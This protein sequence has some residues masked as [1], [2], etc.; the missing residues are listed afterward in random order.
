LKESEF[1]EYFN[2]RF[3]HVPP[4]RRADAIA[5]L[6][7]DE[8]LNSLKVWELSD[9]IHLEFAIDRIKAAQPML[10]SPAPTVAQ[11]LALNDAAHKEKMGTPF[12]PQKR[13]AE[14]RR[15]EALDPDGRVAELGDRELP[16]LEAVAPAAVPKDQKADS[17]EALDAEI[18]E[19]FGKTKHQISAT[20]RRRLHDALRAEQ[21][22][23]TPKQ[24]NESGADSNLTP[25][26]RIN[27]FRA[28]QA[29]K[30]NGA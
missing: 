5:A 28:A 13:L 21:N 1:H 23:D 12:T 27:A 8:E 16:K 19:R 20:E 26:Q 3:S 11:L 18:L 4:G 22:R 17:V 7:K 14:H 9:P 30:T 29:A 2:K 24:I 6:K 10:F 25:A 15:L